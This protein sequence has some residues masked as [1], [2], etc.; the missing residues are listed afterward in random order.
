MRA[1]QFDVEATLR[2]GGA[3]LS[4]NEWSP[5]LRQIL[6]SRFGWRAHTEQRVV[7]VYAL[8]LA[9]PG[10]LGPFLRRRSEPCD[11]TRSNCRNTSEVLPGGGLHEVNHGE[12][13]RIALSVQGW[14]LD[15]IVVDQTGLTGDFDWELTYAPAPD[16]SLGGGQRYPTI[17]DAMED[18]LGLTVVAA[19]APMKVV[20]VDAVLPPTPN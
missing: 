11:E 15:R 10:R 2:P 14:R 5:F 20:V 8:R 18:Q 6:E 7:P 1:A 3:R 17:S 13:A 19:D 12:I 16:E 9:K 4:W